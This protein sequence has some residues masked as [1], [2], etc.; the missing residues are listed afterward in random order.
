[1]I[2]RVT[3]CRQSARSGFERYGDR[4]EGLGIRDQGGR[5]L[6]VGFGGVGCWIL[7]VGAEFKDDTDTRR[8]ELAVNFI[9][10][11]S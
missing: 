3:R 9:W 11:V 8:I 10:K 4:G 1:M 6:S 5:S 7:G 2:P